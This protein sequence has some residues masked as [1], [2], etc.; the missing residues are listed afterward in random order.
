M[1]EM[2]GSR[3]PSSRSRRASRQQRMRQRQ[4]E[5][6]GRPARE[7]ERPRD[8]GA[9]A[10]RGGGRRRSGQGP[11]DAPGHDRRVLRLPVPL[12]LARDRHPQEARRGLRREDP[13][14]LPRLPARADPSQRRQ[15][16][17]GRACANEQGKFWA[18]HDR[19]FDQPGQ[20]RRGRT[21]SRRGRRSGLDAAAFDQCLDS[22]KH[23]A[24]WQKDAADGEK[25]RRA[26]DARVLRQR[27]PG[28]RRAALRELR[29]DV[30]DEELAGA[31]AGP[32]GEAGAARRRLRPRRPSTARRAADRA[33]SWDGPAP[34]PGRAA[35]S[36]RGQRGAEAPLVGRPAR[37]RERRRPLVP[38]RRGARGR[39]APRS[40][41]GPR[42]WRLQQRA[43]QARRGRRSSSSLT[44]KARHDRRRAARERGRG[45][46]RPSARVPAQAAAAPRS[47]A[48]PRPPSRCG[49]RP[50]RRRAPHSSAQAAPA[51]AR[52]AAEVDDRCAAAA[53][54]RPAR[55]RSRA[56]EGSAAGP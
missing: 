54:P 24:E 3:K 8:A 34:P 17:R 6:V 16:R 26:L 22:G 12:L 48:P 53:T 33:V 49:R 7:G 13:H 23:T 2:T 28:G 55:A 9:A 41:R 52:A 42:A 43:Q 20:A 11:A 56:R 38:P 10:H 46:R 37:G 5:Y 40:G 21:S 39:A 4:A 1:G 29:A 35:A 36:A 51:D 31:T 15:G 19:M 18:M 30:I 14:R 27:P 47:S 32:A 44:V 25:A 45:Q 50:R